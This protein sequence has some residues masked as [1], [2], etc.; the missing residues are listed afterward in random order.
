MSRCKIGVISDVNPVGRPTIARRDFL[1]TDIKKGKLLNRLPAIPILLYHKIESPAPLGT[2]SRSLSVHPKRFESQMRWLKSFGYQGLSIQDLLPYLTGEKTGRVFGLT[3]DD[4][5]HNVLQNAAPILD[6]LGFTSTNYFVSGQIGGCN[7]W[8][9][10][11][12][13]PKRRLMNVQEM[14]EWVAN[15]HEAGAHTVSHQ[16]LTDLTLA[17]AQKEIS[18]C[19]K[20]IED[21]ACAPVKAFCYPHGAYNSDIQS[22]VEDAGYTSATT[23]KKARARATDHKFSLPRITV[24]RTDP[25]LK[26]LV[27]CLTA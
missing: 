22:I 18:D 20:V 15:G 25:G 19:R 26:V 23:T 1:M 17:E 7:T 14:R 13:I 10:V 12:N 8:D 24:R 4:G 21:A 16:P 5:Y 2:P 27:R 9:I 3:F 11:R 6:D